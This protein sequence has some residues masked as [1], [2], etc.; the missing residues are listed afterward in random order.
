[1][2][3]QGVVLRY[4]LRKKFASHLSCISCIF[5]VALQSFAVY[6]RDYDCGLAVFNTPQTRMS[7]ASENTKPE[8]LPLK[9]LYVEDDPAIRMLVK[10]ILDRHV[11]TI[12]VGENGAIGL[13]L[14]KEHHP[15]LVVTDV[16]MP[17]MDGMRMARE[18]KALNPKTV[19]I[20]TTAHDR[21]DFLLDAIDIGIDQ[22]LVK[23]IQQPKLVQALQRWSSTILL[24]RKV[25]K[26]TAMI[27]SMKE[28]LEAV[29]NAAPN[30]I[31]WIGNDLRYRGINQ[32]MADAL[33]I[34][35]SECAGQEIGFMGLLGDQFPNFVRS[36]FAGADE[37]AMAE[38]T[39]PIS[40][41]PLVSPEGGSN[42]GALAMPEMPDQTRT[43][44]IMAQKY[45]GGTEA[46]F[47]GTD[48]TERK[49]LELA[50]QRV[51][52]EL[53]QRVAERTV[54][55]VRAKE[56]A[57]AANQ[58][59]STFLANMSHELR[60][61]LNG[62]L[63]LTSL[64]SSAD[65]ITE[66]QQEYLKMTRISGE[67]L[68]HIINDILD[69]SKIEAEKLELEHIPI[70][71]RK[72]FAETAQFFVPSATAKGLHLSWDIHSDVPAALLGD[73]VRI[74]QILT[75]FLGN[76]VKFTQQGSIAVRAELVEM[77]ERDARVRCLVSDTGIGIP[78]DKAGKLFRSFT[79]VDPSFTRKFGGTGLGLAI[80][81]N[82]TEMMGGRVG[83]ES[84]EGR[85]SVFWFEIRLDRVLDGSVSVAPSD[86]RS[87]ERA[88]SELLQ[89]TSQRPLRILLAEDSTINQMVVIETLSPLGC[90]VELAQNGEEAVNLWR[91]SLAAKPFDLVLMDVQ[92]P[93]MDG[94]AATVIIR[95]QERGDV[96]V[97]VIGLTAHASAADRTTCL[98]A[99]MNEVVTKPINFA[100][101]FEVMLRFVAHT[102]QD[103]QYAQAALQQ[104]LQQDASQSSSQDAMY[105]VQHER[106]SNAHNNSHSAV[107]S[108]SPLATLDLSAMSSEP[109]V[110]LRSLYQAVNGKDAVM[111]KL[112]NHFLA[113]Y[114]NELRLLDTAVHER[115]GELLTKT[116]HKLK[117]AVGNFGA[118]RSM[119]LCAKLEDAGRASNFD[120]VATTFQEL[121]SALADVEACFTSG[122]WRELV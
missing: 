67:T 69:I 117:S 97:P 1:M 32:F 52:E 83:F 86:Q 76:A 66:K 94:L 95:S 75:N 96:A 9:V 45:N 114:A 120:G 13:E 72:L 39:F 71:L 23:P 59:K 68:L 31:S 118:R 108:S 105:V 18:I 107:R 82:L 84:N 100:E 53:E 22:Y 111:E 88:Q 74:K 43:Y 61:P 116:A 49:R 26:Q 36:F 93:K 119:E 109:P 87:L 55:L 121:R 4:P 56:Q 60:T 2:A 20:I 64:L 30:L 70:D 110:N 11:E 113:D 62:I 5:L 98:E 89:R 50:M 115:N 104:D 112:I 6:L 41:Q 54:E 24:E 106:S 57:E 44:V 7:T 25:A 51:N 8:K 19:V 58:A 33:A 47:A 79:Q 73:P 91:T 102:T 63:G 34:H 42:D 16:A 81:R 92:M 101:L 38:I 65:N 3:W 85:G 40:Q 48:I 99:G 90:V 14:F 78:T 28:Q 37:H 15:D 122:A 35:P 12:I 77:N 46:V 10:L 27:Q 17:V 80:A 103:S 29:L 21:V